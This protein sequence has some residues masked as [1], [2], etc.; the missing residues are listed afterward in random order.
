MAAVKTTE[1]QIVEVS[2]AC[3][4]SK[5]GMPKNMKIETAIMLENRSVSFAVNRRMPDG[6]LISSSRE[7]SP[8]EPEYEFVCQSFN[9]NEPGDAY[10]NRHNWVDMDWIV[11]DSEVSDSSCSSVS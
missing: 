6:E 7:V 10:I 3:S 1:D 2:D 8:E 5:K 11:V 4:E 9:L